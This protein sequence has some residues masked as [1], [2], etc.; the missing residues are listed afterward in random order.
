[1]EKEEI[2]EAVHRAKTV[3]NATI[4]DFSHIE[5]EEVK[6]LLN[7]LNGKIEDI[8]A[9]DMRL[10]RNQ[11][12]FLIDNINEPL[13]KEVLRQIDRSRENEAQNHDFELSAVEVSSVANQTLDETR[14]RLEDIGGRKVSSARSNAEYERSIEKLVDA[15]VGAYRKQFANVRDVRAGQDVDYICR[16]IKGIT[17]DVMKTHL[18]V[19][20]SIN[21]FSN[22][23]LEG[24]YEQVVAAIG[25]KA[26]I[27]DKDGVRHEITDSEELKKIDKM[28]SELSK[29]FIDSTTDEPGNVGGDDDNHGGSSVRSED[30]Y[31]EVDKA[32]KK[33]NDFASSLQ[34]QTKS[35]DEVARDDAKDLSDNEKAFRGSEEP[36]VSRRKDLEAMFK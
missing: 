20:D 25:E 36:S 19:S 9:G 16:K 7:R 26:V 18:K 31:A 12:A 17:E 8:L 33:F 11:V 13:K 5:K 2:R 4:G 30:E 22:K 14:D 15:A 32:A 28:D 34:S 3:I 23:T 35:N 10:S 29:K 21:G 1:M 6:T 27:V 24:V